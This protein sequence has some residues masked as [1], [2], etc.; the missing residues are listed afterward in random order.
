[1]GG[2]LYAGSV[3][4][5]LDRSGTARRARDVAARGVSLR[6]G[7]RRREAADHLSG[8]QRA[9]VAAGEMARGRGLS[10]GGSRVDHHDQSVQVAD[11]GIRDFLL[12]RDPGAA[13]LQTEARGAVDTAAAFGG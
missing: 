7:S 3:E 8:I 4:I 10:P 1:M 5:F 6:V 9:S 11:L 13:R 2:F 12:R